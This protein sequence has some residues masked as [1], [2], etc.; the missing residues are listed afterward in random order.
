M[1]KSAATYAV[2]CG[3]PCWDVPV[4]IADAVGCVVPDRLQAERVSRATAPMIG[5]GEVRAT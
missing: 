2:K 1:A 5:L 4:G 3:A